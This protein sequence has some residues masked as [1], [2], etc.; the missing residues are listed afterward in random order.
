MDLNKGEL[1]IYSNTTIRTSTHRRRSCR[2]D[3]KIN[4][5][6]KLRRRDRS[7]VLGRPSGTGAGLL[8]CVQCTLT[9]YP[10]KTPFLIQKYCFRG[11]FRKLRPGMPRAGLAD[12]MPGQTS[13][14]GLQDT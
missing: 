11:I 7:S 12:D 1:T 2:K 9:P 3:R 6:E 10:L 5:A 14:R 13:H 8:K 4:L